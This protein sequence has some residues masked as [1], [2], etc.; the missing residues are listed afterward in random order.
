MRSW[1]GAVPPGPCR[2]PGA[3]PPCSTRSGRR[4]APIAACGRTARLRRRGCGGARIQLG[5]ADAAR[6]AV[7]QRDVAFAEN[8]RAAGAADLVVE[9]RVDR[10]QG[11][12]LVVEDLLLADGVDLAAA[13]QHLAQIRLHPH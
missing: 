12:A 9:P 5:V 4:A 6:R 8:P 1:C 7:R 2:V 11:F 13:A 10:L 3:T